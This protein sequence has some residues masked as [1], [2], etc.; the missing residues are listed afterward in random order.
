MWV[1]RGCPFIPFRCVVDDVQA[2]AT[3]GNDISHKLCAVRA[4]ISQVAACGVQV[5]KLFLDRVSGE[6][7]QR[8][9]DKHQILVI[10]ADFFLQLSFSKAAFTFA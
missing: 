4:H 9:A 5:G 7:A 2:P 3:G 1:C 10:P 6:R 8:P